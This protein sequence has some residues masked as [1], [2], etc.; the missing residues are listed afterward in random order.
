MRRPCTR[1]PLSGNARVKGKLQSD[2]VRE[3]DY[4]GTETNLAS[5]C[6]REQLN[7][8]LVPRQSFDSNFASSTDESYN[9]SRRMWEVRRNNIGREKTQA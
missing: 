3:G 7:K 5:M 6:E 1:A 8:I 2:P 9:Q 4:F